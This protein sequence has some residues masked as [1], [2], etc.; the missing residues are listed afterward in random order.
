MDHPITSGASSAEMGYSA[1]VKE[2]E[3]TTA[4]LEKSTPG[5][6]PT[7]PP[8]VEPPASTRLYSSETVSS[9]S[10]PISHHRCLTVYTA[11]VHTSVEA[12]FFA[13][14]NEMNKRDWVIG[15]DD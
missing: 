3:D 14:M 15:D 1:P 9:I 8:T 12:Y 6:L 10:P 5:Q 7:P 4:G 11:R 13:R 2:V